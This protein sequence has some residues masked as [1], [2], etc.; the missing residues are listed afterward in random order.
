MPADI[1]FVRALR[2]EFDGVVCMYHDHANTARKLQP[3]SSSATLYMGLPVIGTTTAHG[4]AFDIAGKG[5]A[6]CGS[7]SA[8]MH[9]AIELSG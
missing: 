2:G 8:A 3:T 5:V 6:D 1:V 7:M 9:Y 4:T